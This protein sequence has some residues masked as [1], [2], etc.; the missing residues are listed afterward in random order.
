M[1]QI[2]TSL[3][4]EGSPRKRVKKSQ[5]KDAR[6]RNDAFARSAVEKF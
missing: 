4:E 5:L 6:S 2:D 1:E 3:E